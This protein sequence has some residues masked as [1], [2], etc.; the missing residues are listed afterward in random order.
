MCTADP[1]SPFSRLGAGGIETTHTTSE[2]GIKHVAH[3]VAEHVEAAVI[4]ASLIFTPPMLML[5]MM[6]MSG[7]VLG[8][9]W[10]MSVLDFEEPIASAA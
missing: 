4:D 7:I 3:G 6:I 5:N 1:L 10:R 9:T 8:R 2:P